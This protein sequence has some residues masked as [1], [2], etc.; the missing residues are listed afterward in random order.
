MTDTSQLNDAL[1]ANYML[2]DLDL[3]SWAGNKT[4]R[5]ASS[6]L[7]ASKG[8][9]KDSGRFVKYLFASADTEL[10]TVRRC[11]N[12][13]RAYV[14]QHSVPFQGDYRLL[15]ATKA[16]EFLTALNGLK[17]D[18]DAAVLAL[19]SVWD[20]RVQQAIHSLGGLADM[21]DYP[22]ASEVTKLFGMKFDLRPVPSEADFSRIN[23]PAEVISALGQRHHT[24]LES[25]MAGVH[26]N[27]KGE[28]LK[29]IQRMATVLGKAGAGEKTRV[30]ETLTTNLQAQVE[31]LRTMNAAGK[32][33]IT[34]LADKIEQQLLAIPVEAFRNSQSESLRVA[35][36][37]KD[38]A[39]EAA[40]DSVWQL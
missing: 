9:T 10:Q 27:L 21:A 29:L 33:E 5:E 40:M 30:C 20:Q 31:L 1:A 25:Q 15:P 11:G 19:E 6:E 17:Q 28:L 3:K 14:N 12:A 34:A 4:D 32:P 38:L 36:A 26:A 13:I 16:I 7:I 18:Y 35:A 8:A 39:V 23:L 22:C 2:V 24:M 37:A